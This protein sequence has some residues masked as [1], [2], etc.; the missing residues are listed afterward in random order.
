[1]QINKRHWYPADTDAVVAMMSDEIWLS[2]VAA[3]SGAERWQVSVDAA[4]SHL[5]A[6]VTAPPKAK[7]FTGDTVKIELDLRWKPAHADGSRD[8]HLKVRAPGLPV[9]MSGGARMAPLAKDG[10]PGTEVTYTIEFTVNM[11][12]VGRSLE[13]KAAPYVSRVID[14]Q[15]EVGDDYLAGRLG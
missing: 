13:A 2:E 1:M 9:T 3:R 11:P 7:R 12:L 10:Q 15:Q 14:T 6:E 4:G 8:G 5:H